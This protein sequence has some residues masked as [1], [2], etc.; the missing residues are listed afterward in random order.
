[1]P[2]YVPTECSSPSTSTRPGTTPPNHGASAEVIVALVFGVIMLLIGLSGLWQGHRLR[3]QY[4]SQGH[5]KHRC[6]LKVQRG[7]IRRKSI[8]PMPSISPTYT[9]NPYLNVFLNGI[10]ITDPTL[11]APSLDSQYTQDTDKP[12]YSPVAPP[13]LRTTPKH[14]TT[15][16]REVSTLSG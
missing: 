6:W 3:H 14:P 2:P 5:H 11:F 9:R 10:S 12:S 13:H 8:I 16:T 1:M 7:S 4:P 15:P